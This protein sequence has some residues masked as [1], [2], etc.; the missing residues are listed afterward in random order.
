MVIVEDQVY[1]MMEVLMAAPISQNVPISSG[2][3]G[4]GRVKLCID[5]TNFLFNWLNNT[6]HGTTYAVHPNE[7]QPRGYVAY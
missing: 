6:W 3:P 4:S 5:C 1:G 7:F 2:S